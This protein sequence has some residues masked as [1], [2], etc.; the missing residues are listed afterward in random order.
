M[1]KMML[2][3]AESRRLILFRT[4]IFRR[5]IQPR[6]AGHEQ[7]LGSLAPPEQA[8]V[9]LLVRRQGTELRHAGRQLRKE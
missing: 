1:W 4:G 5:S 7:P 6:T 2:D 9:L 3:S 8:E